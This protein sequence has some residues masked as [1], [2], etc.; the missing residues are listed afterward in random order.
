MKKIL[1]AALSAA[2]VLSF[3]AI[4]S[5]AHEEKTADASPVVAKGSTAVTI[6]GSMRF[7]GYTDGDTKEGDSTGDKSGYD[8]RVQLGVG[9]NV[10]DNV[11]AYLQLETGD[12]SSD[13]D[14][15][16]D[17]DGSG[18]MSGGSKHA[19]GANDLSIMQAW[20]NYRFDGGGVKVGHLPLALGNKLF[21]DHT[22]SG[23]DAIVVYFDPN[24][25]THIGLLDVKF[26]EGDTTQSGDDI[27]GYVALATYKVDD[28]LNVGANI[29][30]LR[31]NNSE[32]DFYNIGLTAN[33]KASGISYKA[34]LEIQTG[35]KSKGVSQSAMALMLGG[36][37][38]L[39]GTVVGAEL[40][41]G[42]GDDGT[43]ASENANFTNFLTD[44]RYFTTITGYRQAVPGQAGKNSGLANMTY[45]Q[46]NANTKT[47]CPISGKDVAITG[48]ATYMK[49]NEV[50]AGAE[51][52]L[53]TE[54]DAWATWSLAKNTSYTLEAAYLLAGDAWGTSPENAYFVR[55]GINV[56]F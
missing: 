45:L 52:A 36:S 54:I 17:P 33:G 40:G 18:L 39:G 24:S 10:A 46:V 49:L 16:G 9:A 50:A 31:N 43:D 19:D 22:G 29:T 41:Y 32:M 3:A 1:A 47:K 8:T 48:R 12:G 37:M 15:W 11:S 44:T 30:N 51:D 28:S 56:S 2:F 42:S 34:D 13:T 6:D 7:R 23:D 5:A 27:D 53:G 26:V 35:D 25:Q 38:D 21:F 14:A 20:I 55:H 4:S